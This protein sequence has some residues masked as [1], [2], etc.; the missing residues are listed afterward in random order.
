MVRPIELFAL[1]LVGLPAVCGCTRV[2]RARQCQALAE[3][4]NPR[5]DEV[6]QLAQGSQVPAALNAI[7]RHYDGIADDLGPLEFQS[8]ALA[9]AV[10]DYGH[11]LREIAAEARKAATAREAG[12]HKQHMAARREVRTRSSQLKA[13]QK[14]IVAACE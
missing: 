7:A 14:R 2:E 9:N 3:T 10:K 13:A 6:R 12:D 1:L 11:R 8:R 5:L 4:V